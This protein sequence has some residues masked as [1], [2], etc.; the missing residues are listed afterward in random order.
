VVKK[1]LN[2]TSSSYTLAFY[3]I[4]FGALMCYSIARF[5]LK[6]WIEELYI[7]PDFHFSY[8]GF[9]WIKPIGEF[10][11]LIFAVC[12]I[13]SLFVMIGLKYKTSIILFF[14]SFTYIEL[15]DK[16]TYLNHYYFISILSFLLI[17]IPANATFSLDNIINQ[18]KFTNIPRWSVDA[19]KLLITIV[20]LYAGVAKINSDWLIEA[21]PLKIWLQSKYDLPLIGGNLLQMEWVHYAM[22]WGGMLYD[23]SIP[24][25]LML[26]KTRIMAF[27]LVVFFHVFTLI[28]FPIGMFP[29]IMIFSSMVFFS[30]KFHEKILHQIR[31]VIT[32]VGKKVKSKKIQMETSNL[33]VLHKQNLTL[34]AVTSFFIVQILLPFRYQ[35]YPGELFWHEQGY[36]F[37][38]RVM[39]IEKIGYTN[40]KVKNP[41]DGTSFMVD[42]SQHL[43]PFQLKQMSFQPD[44]ILEFAHYLGEKYSTENNKVEVYADSFVAL[45]GRPSKRFIDP[46]INLINEQES[47]KDKTWI[48]P[49][50]DEI[51]GI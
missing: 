4:G 21:M 8:Y 42:S 19:L 16:T 29:H 5:Y 17:F 40:F 11:Y 14:L 35:L 37:S 44:F 30:S 13:S 31:R 46:D 36:R 20:Y 47:F 32:K 39:L 41:N 9:E 1:Y 43:T 26:N 50:E 15:M 45:N 48:L 27:I 33:Y 24:F 51:K 2:K 28:L 49:L 12:F 23:L 10:T 38:W 22:S 7:E 6:G 34:F 25:L 18:K 3:R